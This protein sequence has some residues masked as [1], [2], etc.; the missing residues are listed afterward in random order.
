MAVTTVVV[1]QLSLGDLSFFFA[2]AVSHIM[3][4]IYISECAN[5]LG[6]RHP[7]MQIDVVEHMS[8][9]VYQSLILN[10]LVNSC[11]HHIEYWLTLIWLRRVISVSVILCSCSLVFMTPMCCALFPQKR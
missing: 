6:V 8:Q 5:K 1:M 2:V 9:Q 10:I 3:F 4:G 7:I 11:V